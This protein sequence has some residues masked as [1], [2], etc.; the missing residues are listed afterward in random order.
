M[1]TPRALRHLASLPSLRTLCG[2]LET[3]DYPEKLAS[4]LAGIS[5]SFPPSHVLG[6]DC[7][8]PAS[9]I[10]ELLCRNESPYISYLDHLIQPHV[11][12]G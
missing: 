11:A 3:A 1:A 2:D 9:W 5:H 8:H 4:V 12:P 10:A 6:F 7:N